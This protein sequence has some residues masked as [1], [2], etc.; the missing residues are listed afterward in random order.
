[1]TKLKTYQH[2]TCDSFHDNESQAPAKCV[3]LD[4]ADC[5]IG[6]LQ[7][8]QPTRG[9]IPATVTILVVEYLHIFDT[10]VSLL[11]DGE[12]GGKR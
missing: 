2:L 9:T 5:L 1:M 10:L 4:P 7:A 6:C 12:G 3:G 11:R 8:N